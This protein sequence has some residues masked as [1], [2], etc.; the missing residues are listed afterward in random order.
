MLPYQVQAHGSG[1]SVPWEQRPALQG[2]Q[3]PSDEAA[4][5]CRSPAACTNSFN[6][7]SKMLG[8]CAFR[9]TSKA[10]GLTSSVSTSRELC[11]HPN[12]RQ[13][14]PERPALLICSTQ[15]SACR[16]LAECFAFLYTGVAAVS[17]SSSPCSCDPDA[18]SSPV[19]QHSSAHLP[20]SII[21]CG[22]LG[23]E[24]NC[25]PETDFITFQLNSYG[26][27]CHQPWAVN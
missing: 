20:D 9:S 26:V 15:G 14:S 27:L 11:N 6:A 12:P 16:H 5:G 24:S 2:L 1:F 18:C 17:P 4:A 23:A 13:S 8:C 21:I 10:P 22:R 25:D 3:L 19:P 7:S